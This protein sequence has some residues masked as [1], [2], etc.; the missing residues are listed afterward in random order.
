[1]ILLSSTNKIYLNFRINT[2]TTIIILFF[3]NK[4]INY[5]LLNLYN[6]ILEMF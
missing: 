5:N 4:E 1:M 6:Y 2:I 3:K